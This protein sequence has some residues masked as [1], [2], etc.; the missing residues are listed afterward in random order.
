MWGHQA[1]N[2][3]P[4][5]LLS[6]ICVF[7]AAFVLSSDAG[8]PIFN[9]N[10]Y[11]SFNDTPPNGSEVDG[12]D[13]LQTVSV[14]RTLFSVAALLSYLVMIGCFIRANS[15]DSAMVSPSAST[16][17]D[18]R[19]QDAFLLFVA[20]AFITVSLSG[21]FLTFFK[22]ASL[23]DGST[24]ALAEVGVAAQLLA[25]WASVNTCHVFA[26]S[27]FTLGKSFHFFNTLIQE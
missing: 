21:V 6:A 1:W 4:R 11:Q 16:K 7:Q 9:C 22:L 13:S 18:I 20:F 12:K 24:Y 2:Y 27:S 23:F 17:E 5:V 19:N 15:K 26:I 8:C 25:L 14:Y 3:I 10:L